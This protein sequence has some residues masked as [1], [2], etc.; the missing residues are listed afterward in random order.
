M[1]LGK[2]V[3]IGPI[4][5]EDFGP[6]FCWANDVV[7]ARLDFAYRP[8]DLISHRQW[9]ET[10]GKDPTRIVFAIRKARETAIIG[11]VQISNINTV[12]GSA[13]LGIRIGEERFRGQGFGK[14]ALGLAL[15]FCWNH[16]N[17]HRVQLT[18]FKHNQRAIR[19]YQALGFKKEG[20]LKQAAFIDGERI[21]VIVMAVLRPSQR[22]RQKQANV[23]RAK[24]VPLVGLPSAASHAVA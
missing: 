19:T 8:I 13:D 1:L 15:N 10:I 5:P 18:V 22:K 9:C 21:D 3:S 6:L 12:Y 16:V 20:L 24:A 2:L 14:D 17:L 23:L 11:Y 7:A 4:F